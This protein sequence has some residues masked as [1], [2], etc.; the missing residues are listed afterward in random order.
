[1]AT[2]VIKPKAVII[3]SST[4]FNKDTNQSGD[5]KDDKHKAEQNKT[6]HEAG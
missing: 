6:V 1:M 2:K 3:K 5:K 4:K